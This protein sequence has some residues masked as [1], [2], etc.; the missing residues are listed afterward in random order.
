MKSLEKAGR[1]EDL[2]VWQKAQ[3]LGVLVYSTSGKGPI[4]KDFGIKNQ[5]RRASL[6]I[7]TNI[8]EGQGRYSIKSSRI[9]F[10]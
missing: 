4:A 1:F 2:I 7:S 3:D 6:S 5:I 9:I 8:A 10:R